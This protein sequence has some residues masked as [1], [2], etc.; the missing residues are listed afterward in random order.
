MA[1]IDPSGSWIAKGV[2]QCSWS[3][4]TGS[5]DTVNATSNPTLPDKTV[6]VTATA[7]N[8]VVVT[9]VGSN[10]SVASTATYVTLNDPNGNALTFSSSRTEQILENP[11]WIKPVAS[12]ATG[13]TQ[14]INIV[15]ISRGER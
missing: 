15:L 6:V 1:T 7:F 3:A 9:M 12:G 14:S 4:L 5:G 10:Y 13:G 11:R 8:S 2:H